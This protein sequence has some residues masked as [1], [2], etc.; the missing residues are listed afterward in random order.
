MMARILLIDDDISLHNLL[1]KFLEQQG[2]TVLHAYE[3]REGIRVVF[4]ERPDIVV[5]DVMMPRID[6]WDT[7]GRIREMSKIPVILLTAKSAE[8]D[9]LRG[10]QIGSDDYVTKPFSFA[11]LAARIGAVIRRHSGEETNTEV[12][13]IGELVLD[14]SRHMLTRA[15]QPIQLTPTEFKLLEVLMRQPGR[16]FT[17]EQ[18]VAAVWGEEY[19]EEIGY[20]R[21]YIWHL[22]QKIEPDPNNPTYIRNERG[23]GYKL[24]M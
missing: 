16:V 8:Q 5:L 13:H 18:L 9:K 12:L 17:Q 4:D 10:F 6:G 14:A 7:L 3:G 15:N 1:G 19:A 20:I 2:Y 22:R 11:E 23:I 24:E 21:R